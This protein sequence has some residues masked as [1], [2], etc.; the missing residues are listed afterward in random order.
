SATSYRAV[1]CTYFLK[2]LNETSDLYKQSLN[3]A[4]NKGVNARH[5][6]IEIPKETDYI[7][8]KKYYKGLN[9]FSSKH[10][11]NAV[12]ISHLYLNTMTNAIGIKLFLSFAQTSPVNKLH[13]FLIR[14]I[15]IFQ[16]HI[17]ILMYTIVNNNI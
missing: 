9:P 4:L 11:L 3:S 1:I 8:S 10:P 15:E 7:D 12:E 2:G 17:K 5:P 14:G 13:N 16:K 6:Y